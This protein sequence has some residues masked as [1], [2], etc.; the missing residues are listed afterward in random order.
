MVKLKDLTWKD[1]GI[2]DFSPPDFRTHL[3]YVSCMKE[4]AE[5]LEIQLNF[6]INS[7]SKYKKSY[8]FKKLRLAD[9]IKNSLDEEYKKAIEENYFAK[10]CSMWV[11]VKSYYLIFNLFLIL[12]SLINDDKESLNYSHA[13]SIST[14]RNLLKSNKLEF[15]KE[16]FNIVSSCGDALSF[17]SVSGDTLR[18]DIEENTRAK[19]ILKKLCKYKFDNFM[20]DEKIKN[21]R[22]KEDQLKRDLF[23]ENSHISLFEFFYWYRIKTNYRDLSFLDQKIYEKDIVKFYECYYLLTM[24]FYNALKKLINEISMKRFGEEII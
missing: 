19:S 13:R 12:H 20:R 3:N 8:L 4:L 10:I 7:K 21:F 11:P 15:N 5:G 17:S 9:M 6:S 24:N 22:T 18:Y 14:F 2:R 23:F 1:I 16:E